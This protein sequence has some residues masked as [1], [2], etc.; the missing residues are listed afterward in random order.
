MMA[1]ELDVSVQD[2]LG[3]EAEV[4]AEPSRNE[5]VEQLARINEQLA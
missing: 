5:L 1:E 2:L 3:A 4:S